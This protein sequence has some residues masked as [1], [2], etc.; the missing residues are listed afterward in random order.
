VHL[1]ATSRRCHGSKVHT[2]LEVTLVCWLQSRFAPSL[3][4][5]QAVGPCQATICC[6]RFSASERGLGWWNRRGVGSASEVGKRAMLRARAFLE[7]DVVLA[8]LPT[9]AMA[10]AVGCLAAYSGSVR[11][12]KAM[13]RFAVD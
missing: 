8:M 13:Q 9:S 1:P 10:A 3:R 6:A 4:S 5:Y 7:V 12:Q 11:Q 2:A